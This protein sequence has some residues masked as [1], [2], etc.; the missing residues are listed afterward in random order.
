MQSIGF[1]DE[2]HVAALRE[3]LRK[4][5]DEKLLRFGKAAKNMCSPYANMGQ[6]PR[7]CFVIQLNEAK[8]EWKRRH[9]EESY[10]ACQRKLE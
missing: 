5:S 7:E 1:K 4:M 3:R 6:P 9:A 8:A 10:A 2:F